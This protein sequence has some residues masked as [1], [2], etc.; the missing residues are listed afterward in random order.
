VT[1]EDRD[2]RRS[3]L[4]RK[5]FGE[6]GDKT[7][8]DAIQVAAALS[9]PFVVFF[10]GYLFSERRAQ[11]EALE[12]YLE[13]MG[14]LLLDGDLH[15][16]EDGTARTIADARTSTVLSR[17]DDTRKGSVVLFLYRS[18]LIQKDQPLVSL[19]GA[20]LSDAS[21]SRANLNGANLSGA[22]LSGADL[23][24]AILNEADLRR[25]DLRD[26]N[27][28][29]AFLNRAEMAAN[30]VRPTP[31]EPGDAPLLVNR[32]YTDLSGANLSGAFLDGVGECLLGADLS[33]ANL[34]GTIGITDEQLEEQ[35]DVRSLAGTTMPSGRERPNSNDLS[36]RV[37]PKG[38]PEGALGSYLGCV[39]SSPQV[40][41]T[42]R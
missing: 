4:Y 3:W 23:S 40:P 41:P 20:D 42:G 1:E 16:S 5:F 21:L 19:E 9:I 11:D 6:K 31:N 24:G 15:N 18:R 35:S 32:Q 12:A 34:S 26:A 33:C 13:G 39:R 8:F 29:G 28:R 37:W 38:T 2:K 25:A 27:L 14:T 7:W 10:G 17:L 36:R 30:M 22:N